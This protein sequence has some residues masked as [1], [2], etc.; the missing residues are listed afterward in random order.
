[1]QEDHNYLN[2]H[3][4]ELLD[5][6]GNVIP[7]SAVD[8]ENLS[9][10]SFPYIVRQKPGPWNALGE[11]K[12]IF[13]NKHAVYL[14]D[15]P[16]KSLFSRQDRAF[17]HGCIRTQYPLD[18]AEVLLQGSEWDRAKIDK[19]IESR[20]TTRVFFDRDVD[21]LLLYLTAGYYEGDGIGFFKD[22]YDRDRKVLKQLNKV[23]TRVSSNGKI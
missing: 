14:H 6:S 3:H 10:S 21:V 1:M 4:F 7:N 22:V 11:V 2:D 19:T 16:S 20:V 17:S 9:A 8:Y 23:D 18:L 15:T 5:G 13:P 12:F